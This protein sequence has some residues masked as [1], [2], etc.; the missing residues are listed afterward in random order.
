MG[1]VTDVNGDAI[2]GASV[3]LKEV[4]S[5]DPRTIVATENGMFQFNDVTPGTTYQLSISAKDFAVWL[6]KTSRTVKST[7]PPGVSAY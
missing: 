1:T 5:N 6:V 3:V 2:P 7:S 4:E